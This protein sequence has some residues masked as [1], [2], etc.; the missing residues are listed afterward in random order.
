MEASETEEEFYAIS[1]SVSVAA[2]HANRAT[3]GSLASCSLH[4][5]LGEHAPRD[6]AWWPAEPS[7]IHML[8]VCPSSCTGGERGCSSVQNGCNSYSCCWRKLQGLQ[9]G[10]ERLRILARVAGSATYYGRT[11][12]TW[13]CVRRTGYGNTRAYL[14]FNGVVGRGKVWIGV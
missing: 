12:T 3:Y 6:E 14:A 5:G 1:E 13:S 4:A 9:R 11:T 7:H 8:S 2:K 10:R